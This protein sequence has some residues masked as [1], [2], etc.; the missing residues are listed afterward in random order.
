MIP[1]IACS[2]IHRNHILL[3]FIK[4]IVSVSVCVKLKA[5]VMHFVHNYNYSKHNLFIAQPNICT[6]LASIQLAQ[7]FPRLS[8]TAIRKLHLKFDSPQYSHRYSP[9]LSIHSSLHTSI[10]F[11]RI[12]S[13]DIPAQ[14]LPK[15]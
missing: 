7:N 4:K 5:V 8:Y 9:Q 15:L 6:S 11:T 2:Y 3:M 12:L 10:S 13:P 14:N 1:V